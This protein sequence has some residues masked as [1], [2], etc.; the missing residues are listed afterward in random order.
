MHTFL[1]IFFTLILVQFYASSVYSDESAGNDIKI[2]PIQFSRILP[3]AYCDQGKSSIQGMFPGGE[4]ITFQ[5]FGYLSERPYCLIAYRENSKI[6]KI[7]ISGVFLLDTSAYRFETATSQK[8]YGITL[9]NL[10]EMIT[11]YQNQN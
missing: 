6:D 9:L 4:L 8:N 10:A 1:K 3:H 2:E 7:I 5:R 11:K